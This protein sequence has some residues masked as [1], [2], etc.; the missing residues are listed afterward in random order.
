LNHPPLDLAALARSAR[1]RSCWAAIDGDQQRYW[2][3]Q[4]TSQRLL[5]HPWPEAEALGGEP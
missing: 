1:A 5:G 3:E 4:A 2:R